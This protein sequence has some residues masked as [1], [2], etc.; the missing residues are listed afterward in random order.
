[1]KITILDKENVEKVNG[2][3]R[4]YEFNDYRVYRMLG[5]EGLRKYLYKSFID[6]VKLPDSLVIIAQD[7][8]KICGLAVVVLLPWDTQHFKAKMAKIDYFIAPG[9]H[10]QTLILKAR[11]LSFMI[12][13]CKARGLVYLSC[14][15]DAGDI[16]GIHALEKNGFLLMDTIVTYVF[17]RHKHCLPDIRG[18][19]KTRPFKEN[20]LPELMRIAQ[21]AFSRDRFHLDTRI[22][23]KKSDGLFRKWIKDS[24]A[25]TD[26]NKIFVVQKNSRIAGFLTFEL[27]PGLEQITGYKI[28]GHGLSAVSAEAK[29]AYVSLVKAAVQEVALNYDCLE[30]DTQL[31]NYEVIRVW[32][33]FGFD[34]VRTKHTFH[35][36]LKEE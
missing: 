27:N 31:N 11:M 7:N 9:D 24:S 15:L 30:F 36:W 10:R 3:L 35:R 8:N 19:H 1:M 33:K 25:R 13:L 32:Q 6:V 28:A 26:L 14:R 17:N 5:E 23:F 29:G 12:K 2:L 21:K 16:C 18:I 4:S 22:P 34:Q 20:D